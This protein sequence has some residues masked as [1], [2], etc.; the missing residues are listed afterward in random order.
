MKKILEL[1]LS[2]SLGGLELYMKN[3]SENFG[4]KAV[5]AKGSRL[6]KEFEKDKFDFYEIPKFGVFKL[7][8]IIDKENID[9]LHLHYTKDILIA[10]LAKK[11]SSKKPKIVQSRH[12][13]MTRFK[14][15]LWHKF[16]YKNMDLIIAV[17][18]MLE[19]QL[20]KFIPSDVRPRIQTCYLGVK[21]P[22]LLSPIQKLMLKKDLGLDNAFCVGIVGRIEHAKGQHI[23]LSATKQL[24]ENGINARCVVLGGAMDEAYLAELESKYKQDK[25][26]GHVNN[27]S[28]I[29]QAFDVLVLATKKETFGLVLVEAMRCGVCVVA[30]D[31]G[32]PLEI[33]DNGVNGLLFESFNSDD[34]AKKLELLANDENLRL[35]LAKSGKNK[36]DAKFSDEVHYEK[37]KEILE[38]L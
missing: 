9:V 2:H 28:E 1:C 37:I 22:V 17:T 20:I 34:L 5:V 6:A 11:I 14:S 8:S 36:A 3:L 25:F 24:R 4:T 13:H 32:G 15:D 18:K 10:V 33:I 26:M 12:M 7:A 31:S 19:N 38:N 27:V 30:S 35:S 16:L 23:V 21:K 29:M